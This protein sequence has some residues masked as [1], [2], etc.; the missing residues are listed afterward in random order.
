MD[1]QAW[2]RQTVWAWH[3]ALNVGEVDRLVVLAC[4]DV[5]VGGPRGSGRGAQLLREWFGRSGIRL[6]PVRTV[7]R[8]DTV[9][10]EQD[11]T[12][13]ADETVHRLASVF[14]VRDGKIASVTRYPDLRAA[15]T[16]AGLNGSDAQAASR[17]N[18]G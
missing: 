16:A 6:Q 7:A 12:W 10:V 18:H 14:R 2:A 17:R 15:L 5:E 13:P 3:Q 8:G 4:E 9:V 1:D 11:A